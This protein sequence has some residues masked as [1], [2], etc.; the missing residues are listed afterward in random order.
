MADR[1]TECLSLIKKHAP[2]SIYVEWVQTNC[3]DIANAYRNRLESVEYGIADPIDLPMLVLTSENGTDPYYKM[4]IDT[5]AMRACI[6]TA[7][8]QV[9][10]RLERIFDRMMTL[11]DDYDAICD[12]LKRK[13]LFDS[14]VQTRDRLL[15]EMYDIKQQIAHL[16]T[17]YMTRATS[18]KLHA[19]MERASWIETTFQRQP[20]ET[21]EMQTLVQSLVQL[22]RDMVRE[23]QQMIGPSRTFS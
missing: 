21:T 1:I 6:S 22:N 23:V 4:R 2:P 15:I 18:Q 10:T 17:A 8:P 19:L 5:D 11:L 20:N 3:V 16:D 9:S 7:Y 13:E 12:D 14:F